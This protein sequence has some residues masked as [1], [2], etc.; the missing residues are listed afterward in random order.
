MLIMNQDVT[1]LVNLTEMKYL[2]ACDRAYY[3]E[4]KFC[5]DGIG[6]ESTL[7]GYET[8]ARACEVLM[9]IAKK[10]SEENRVYVMPIK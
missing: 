9:D 7:G 3:A 8:F 1:M 5:T 10:Y 2:Y 6:N 4:I